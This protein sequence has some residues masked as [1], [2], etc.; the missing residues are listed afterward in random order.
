MKN[1][2]ILILGTAVLGTV[3][4]GGLYCLGVKSTNEQLAKASANKDELLLLVTKDD[5]ELCKDGLRNHLSFQDVESPDSLVF[6]CKT[7]DGKFKVTTK[8]HNLLVTI[9]GVYGRQSFDSLV[10]NVI[11]KTKTELQKHVIVEDYEL[12]AID[13]YFPELLQP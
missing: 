3:V 2:N 12:E 1:E 10:R 6:V 8:K 9:A 7:L 5:V 11:Q 13:Q 4:L